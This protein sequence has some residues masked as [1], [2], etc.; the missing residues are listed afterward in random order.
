MTSRRNFIKISAVG[1]AAAPLANLLMSNS[2]VAKRRPEEFILSD[3]ALSVDDPQA[4]ALHYVE[5][6]TANSPAGRQN[7]QFCSNCQIF[8]GTPG[9]EW[10]PCAIFSYRTHPKTRQPF[11]VSAKGWC[12]GWAPR[13]SMR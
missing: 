5:D 10:G 6:A 2:A 11:M 8:T 7:H 3:S 12:D 1:L 9:S 13:A 4:A